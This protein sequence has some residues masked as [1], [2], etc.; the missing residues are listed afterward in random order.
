MLPGRLRT[1]RTLTM[2][3]ADATTQGGLAGALVTT[4]GVST[5]R[6]RSIVPIG[7]PSC[8]PT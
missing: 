7:P 6:G 5:E 1:H 8:R 3:E 2:T 4:R